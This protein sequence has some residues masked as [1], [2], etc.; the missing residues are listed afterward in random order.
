MVDPKCGDVL[1]SN[2]RW[3]IDVKLCDGTI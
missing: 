2:V 1:V 3:Q